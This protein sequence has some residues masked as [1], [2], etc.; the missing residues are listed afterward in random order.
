MLIPVL[1]KWHACCSISMYDEE[2][3]LAMSVGVVNL[4][5]C[6]E[7]LKRAEVLLI[8]LWSKCPNYVKQLGIRSKATCNPEMSLALH[9]AETPLTLFQ[10]SENWSSTSL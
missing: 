8:S 2:K 1:E 10:P 7:A 5:N 9:Q 3:Q 6:V 4:W